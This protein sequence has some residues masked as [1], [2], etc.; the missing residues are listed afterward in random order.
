PP[1]SSGPTT[2]PRRSP[3]SSRSDRPTSPASRADAGLGT[4]PTML[5]AA[6]RRGTIVG[7]GL[8]AFDWLR[9]GVIVAVAVVLAIACRRM[10]V[11]FLRRGDPERVATDLVARLLAY[12]VR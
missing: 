12:L 8:T 7:S 11:R 3:H 6:A 10:L 5:G 4:P 2:S 1:P 9:A